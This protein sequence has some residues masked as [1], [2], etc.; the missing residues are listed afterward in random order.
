MK[1]KYVKR[2]LK[3]CD[4]VQRVGNLIGLRSTRLKTGYLTRKDLMEILAKIETMINTTRG[5]EH[6]ETR[7][8]I[9]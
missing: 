8:N 5:M 7:D 2:K 4:I 9:S 1:T 3:R 6:A